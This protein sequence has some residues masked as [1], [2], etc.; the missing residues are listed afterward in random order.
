MATRVLIVA[1]AVLS[2]MSVAPSGQAPSPGS[3]TPPRTS[4]GDPDIQGNFT[5]LWEVGT[6]FERPD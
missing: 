6:P 2:V 3:W 1:I 4:W 5:N